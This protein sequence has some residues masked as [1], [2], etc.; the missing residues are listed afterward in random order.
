MDNYILDEKGDPV[1]EPDLL[2][3]AKWFECGNRSLKR[4]TVFDGV[5]VSTVFL[6]LDHGF[7]GG[8]PVLWETMVFGGEHDEYQERYNTKEQALEGH[9]R[10]IDMV[11]K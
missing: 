3:W 6:G 1:K 4:D 10:I 5:D 8:A 11:K 2:K 9:E 7:N